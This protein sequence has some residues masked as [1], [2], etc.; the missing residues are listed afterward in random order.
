V[1]L[2]PVFVLAIGLEA[3]IGKLAAIAKPTKADELEL[4]SLR[5]ELEYT[6]KLKREYVEKHPEHRKF[7]YA[8]EVAEEKAKQEREDKGEGPSS[9]SGGGRGGGGGNGLYDRDGRLVSAFPRGRALLPAGSADDTL[10]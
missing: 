9:G 7:V 6:S 4:A 8:R 2:H 5:A 10:R 3:R 1:L